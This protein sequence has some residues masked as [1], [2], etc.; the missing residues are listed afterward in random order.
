MKFKLKDFQETAVSALLKRIS[1]ARQGVSAG[2]NQAIILSA[3][4]ASG[5]TITL[6]ALLE[7]IVRGTEEH[8]AN[9]QATFLWVSDSPELNA[10]SM[11]KI[12]RASD[13]FPLHKLIMV[14]TS[15]DQERVSPGNVYF[16][17]TSKLGK[18]KLLT[19][20]GDKRTYTFWQTVANT[21]KESPEDFFVIIDEAHRG[22]AMSPQERNRAKT[23]V[24]KF[25]LG[26]EDDRMPPVPIILGMSATPQRFDELLGITDRSKNTL[27]ITPEDVRD[28]GLLKDLILVQMPG[29]DTPGDLTLLEQATHRWVD[30][31]KQWKKYC[32]DQG[33]EEIVKPAL[34]VQVEDGN[35]SI[36]T[37]T[38]LNEAVRVIERIAGPLSDADF[39]HCFQ[40]DRV[41]EAG[42]RQIR[43]IEA[44]RIQDDSYVRIVFFKMSLTTGWDCPRA[45]VMMS[46]RKARD[47]TLIAQL[48]GR[49]IRTPL[50]RKIESSE[51]LNTVELFL[52][53]YDN[54]ALDQILNELRNPDAETGLGTD[55]EAGR[56]MVTYPCAAGMEDVLR[57]VE[58]LPGYSIGR[59]A[60]LPPVKRV[61]RLASRLTLEDEIDPLAL[62]EARDV[63]VNVLL[64]VRKQLKERDP[65]FAER[66]SDAG[67]LEI[68]TFG[69]Q[70]G[71][72]SSY[73]V[74]TNKVPL[75][76]ENIEDVFE[77]CGRAIGAGEGIHKEFW[78]RLCDPD[79]PLRPKLELY[80]VLCDPVTMQK[81]AKTAT[82]M[83]DVLY[84]RNKLKIAALPSSQQE[85]YNHLL[86]AG[87]APEVIFRK[88]PP[89]LIV[90]KGKDVWKHHL[91]AD[92][93]GNFSIDLNS[94]EKAV[95]Q[96]EMKREDFVGWFRNV[97]RKEWAIAV[98]YDDRGI[99]PFYP[100]FVIIRHEGENLVADLIDPHNSKLDDTWAKAK[101]LAY[102]ANRHGHQF[103]RLEI[104]I[105]EGGTLKRMDV[106]NPS[107]RKKAKKFQSNNDVDAL[108]V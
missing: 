78:K 76:P 95:I 61:M 72:L 29:R 65:K 66:V 79:N 83:F 98:P 53:H 6:A 49:M 63:C 86:G 30:F 23:I 99:K 17:N 2:V 20:Q 88:M 27:K 92:S 93:N 82:E 26:S 102:Y 37:R 87:K 32:R 90:R 105:V 71:N 75:T 31:G 51:V 18:E 80:E 24:Q 89:E 52:P 74:G 43:K 34:V 103:G 13:A 9:P 7:Y 44:S 91:Y 1:L 19:V 107:V 106:N 16:I 8:E 15:F 10:Q 101:G 3:P 84:K 35:E 108:F 5:K 73:K 104:V 64:E 33:I 40:E 21:A 81:L 12:L 39:A 57:F 38:D 67:E 68:V 96:E 54:E 4:T 11:D 22:M 46:F 62:D 56:N 41:V 85:H 48:I 42:G 28:S 97:D 50:S 70:V 14:D 25:I 94:W 45:E 59:A 55:A 69:V 60:E 100:D 58:S 36:L 77:Q 47:H